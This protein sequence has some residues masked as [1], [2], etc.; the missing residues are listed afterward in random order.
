MRATLLSIAGHGWA[1]FVDR[2]SLPPN[3]LHSSEK[4]PPCEVPTIIETSG[5]WTQG[6][7]L[8]Y[9]RADG[10]CLQ[11]RTSLKGIQRDP[12][13]SEDID[14]SFDRADLGYAGERDPE[15]GLGRK[16]RKL[17]DDLGTMSRPISPNFSLLCRRLCRALGEPDG[18]M[19][20]VIDPA[21][22]QTVNSTTHSFQHRICRNVLHHP[23]VKLELGP[24]AIT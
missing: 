8:P 11:G 4:A 24:A 19:V 16:G 23:R 5:C 12:A 9:R 7:S 17:I 3:G 22:A 2:P 18:R 13:V 15:A 21:D 10:L 20:S 1:T 6:A 14:L